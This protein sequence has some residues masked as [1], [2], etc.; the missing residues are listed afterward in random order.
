MLLTF[1]YCFDDI[2][3]DF[4]EIVKR[5]INDY[6][7]R[8]C[9]YVIITDNASTNSILQNALNKVIYNYIITLNT[10]IIHIFY[11][12]YILQLSCNALMK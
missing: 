3:A 12:I 1:T 10:F 2:S 5:I 4:A 7:I 9:I 6:S 8:D 11:L